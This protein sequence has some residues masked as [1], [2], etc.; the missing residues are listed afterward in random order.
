MEDNKK[1][2]IDFI[3]RNGPVL[4]VQVSKELKR[5]ILMSSALLAELVSN[6]LILIS[7]TKR[8]GS[9]FY[10]LKGQEYKL[11]QLS[12]CL[13]GKEKEA[14]DLIKSKRI[15]RDKEAEPWQ[16]VA[17]RHLKDFAIPLNVKFKDNNEIFW[18]WYLLN[19]EEAKNIIKIKL[20]VPKT[21]EKQAVKEHKE[22]KSVKQESEKE[23]VDKKTKP[24]KEVS[25]K[26]FLSKFKDYFDENNIKIVA[27]E[28]IR[29]NREFN[30]IV[31][32]SSD[33]GLLRYYAKAKNKKTISDA[34][35]SLA[36]NEAQQKKLPALFLSNGKLTKKAEK[37]IKDNLKGNLVFKTL[38]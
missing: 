3:R 18:K 34:D 25:K 27:T 32:I 2:I 11:Q 12:N 16:R 30:F 7:S 37:Y 20:N 10:Y 14:Y 36:Y 9:P 8:G 35:I 19:N 5:D 1:I 22:K 33:I 17:L 24:K 13:K 38:N 29:K 28:I 4:P 21:D 6:K 26:D 23:W 15:V 31:E